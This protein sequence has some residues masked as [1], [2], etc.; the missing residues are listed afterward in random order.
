M[1]LRL[2]ASAAMLATAGLLLSGCGNAP[3]TSNKDTADYPSAIDLSEDFDPNA[4]F[5][6]GYTA[7]PPSWDPTE[8]TSSADRIP[9]SPVYDTLF[10]ESKDDPGYIP[11][12][13]TEFEP[14]ADGKSVT[15]TLREGLT[16]SDGTQF[17]AEAAKFNLDR[18]RADGSRLRGELYQIESVEVVDPLTI[19]INVSGGIK[20]LIT[21]LVGRAGI[22]VSPAAAQ[23]GILKSQ[24]VGIGPYVAT[25]IVAGDQAT[26]ELSENYWDPAAQKV[27][28]RTH[29]FIADDQTRYNALLSGEIDGAQINPDQLDDAEKAGIQVVTKPSALFLNFTVN[30]TFAPF[31]NVEVRKAINM[32]IDRVGIAEGLYDGHCTPQVQ[33]F[34]E[35]GIAYNEEVGDGLDVYPYDPAKAKEILA[36]NGV[37]N[38]EIETLAP[39]VTIYTKFAEVIQSTFKEAG[40]TVSVRPVPSAQLVQ[41]FILDKSAPTISSVTTGIIDPDFLYGTFVSPQASSN[42]GGTTDPEITKYAIEGANAIEDAD[43]TAAYAKMVDAWMENPPHITPVCMIHL[44]GGY[45][46]YVSGASQNV[47]GLNDLRYLAVKKH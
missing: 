21:S 34:P 2:R 31:D 12:L 27:A 13:A 5:A 38:L 19:K 42:P 18:N 41:E 35:G 23:S 7:F 30:T 9:Y 33:P 46:D 8:S 44:A 22:M 40:I 47:S 45:A 4:T 3:T 28:K 26:Y 17:D 16:F 36:E 1:G 24:P 6:F 25:D 43:R 10:I 29:R 32:S 39:N 14:A 15:L 20:P 37:T 11:G